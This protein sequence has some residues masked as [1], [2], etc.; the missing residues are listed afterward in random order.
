MQAA[1]AELNDAEA[2]VAYQDIVARLQEGCAKSGHPV[3]AA[4]IDWK[5]YNKVP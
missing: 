5:R 2:A 1:R 3:A 4:Y